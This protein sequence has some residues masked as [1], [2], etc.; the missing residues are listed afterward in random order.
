[1]N[2]YYYKN[3]WCEAA[4]AHAPDCI[5]WHDEGTGPFSKETCESNTSNRQWRIKPEI[6]DLQK[7]NESLKQRIK[8]LEEAVES[9]WGVI[10]NVSGGNWAEQRLDWREV[11]I[12]WRDEQFHPVWK[13]VAE[14][15]V[16]EDKP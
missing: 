7:E 1:M 10:A 14:R 2:Q 16:K 12:R 11:A 13:S 4:N 6:K 3:N 15:K 9:A 5:C 8:R